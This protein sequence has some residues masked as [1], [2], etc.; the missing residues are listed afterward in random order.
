MDKILHK[1]KLV[2]IRIRS[3]KE[4]SLPVVDGDEPLQVL[5]LKHKKGYQVKAH[6]HK[7]TTRTTASLQECLVVLKGKV[8]IDLYGS[9]KK[10]VKRLFLKQGETFIFV[11]GGHGVHFLEDTEIIEIKNGPFSP[12]RLPI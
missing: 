2:G 12:D 6:Y 7:P 8:R 3:L 4:G 1:K 11:S 9:E 5:T 10:V